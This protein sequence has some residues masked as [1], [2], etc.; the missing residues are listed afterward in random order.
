[1]KKKKKGVL[2]RSFRFVDILIAPSDGKELYG[3]EEL[4]LTY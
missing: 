1:M 2:E 3:T 4:Y